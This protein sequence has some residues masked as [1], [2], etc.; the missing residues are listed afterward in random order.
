MN[1]RREFGKSLASGTLAAAATLVPGV[2]SAQAVHKWRFQSM[3]QAG[4]VNQKVYED[5]TKTLAKVAN[6]R[7][8]KDPACQGVCVMLDDAASMPNS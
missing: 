1:S 8:K 6:H 3:W 2:A 5:W 4:S 7:A